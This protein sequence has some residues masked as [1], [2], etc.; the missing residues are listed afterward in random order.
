MINLKVKKSSF[1]SLNKSKHVLFDNQDDYR[2][3]LTLFEAS[4]EESSAK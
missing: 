2:D 3:F 4:R 1:F